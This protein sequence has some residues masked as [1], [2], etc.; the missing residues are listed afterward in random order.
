[1]AVLVSKFNEQ[2]SLHVEPA[3]VGLI[4]HANGKSNLFDAVVAMKYA[5]GNTD[6]PESHECR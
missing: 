1:L 6:S 2:I 4:P 3:N 5:Y